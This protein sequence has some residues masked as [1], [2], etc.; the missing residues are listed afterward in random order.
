MSNHARIVLLSIPDLDGLVVWAAVNES[1]A[2]PDDFIDEILMLH[3]RN[4][5]QIYGIPDSHSTVLRAGYQAATPL[6]HPNQRLPW[7]AHNL[8]IVAP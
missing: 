5:D 7:D 2:T 4:L 8:S 3:H 1:L 6:L